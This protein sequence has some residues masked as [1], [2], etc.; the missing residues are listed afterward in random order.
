MQGVE[1]SCHGAQRGARIHLPAGA[2]RGL[3]LGAQVRHAP[4]I[5]AYLADAAGDGAFEMLFQ[6]HAVAAYG[7]YGPVAR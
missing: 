5:D 4:S 3:V 2:V 6:H 1:P 7:F